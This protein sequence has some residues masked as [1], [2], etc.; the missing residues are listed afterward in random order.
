MK[1]WGINSSEVVVRGRHCSITTMLK[2]RKDWIEPSACKP[3]TQLPRIRLTSRIPSWV[4]LLHHPYRG[5][6]RYGFSVPRI[7]RAVSG[8]V[9]PS[10]LHLHNTYQFVV[11]FF[12]TCSRV[13]IPPTFNC[14]F[15]IRSFFLKR[16]G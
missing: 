8:S 3:T 1:T 16:Y 13:H 11:N 4:P 2:T 12:L 7:L 10:H 5:R 9:C 6:T 14:G 15:N